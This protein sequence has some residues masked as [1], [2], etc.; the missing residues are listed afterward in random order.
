MGGPV[1]KAGFM[2]SMLSMLPA[3]LTGQGAADVS[4]EQLQSEVSQP[5]AR[6]ISLARYSCHLRPDITISSACTFHQG[7]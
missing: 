1:K 6:C 2:G 7:M 3:S 4:I 5:Q